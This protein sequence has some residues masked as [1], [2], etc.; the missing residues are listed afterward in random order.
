M[1]KILKDNLPNK[2]E[3]KGT[4]FKDITN[5]IVGRLTVLYPCERKNNKIYWLC[6]CNC[7]NYT[8]VI[9]NSL[10]NKKTKS[11]GCYTKERMSNYQSENLNSLIGKTFG[12][13]TVIEEDKII[14]TNS[15]RKIRTYKC[16][17]DCGNI[18][19]SISNSL[20]GGYKKSCGCTTSYGNSLIEKL[21]NDNNILFKKEYSFE[22][23]RGE[24]QRNPLRFDF[25]ILDKNNNLSYLIEY[26]GKQHFKINTKY[27]WNT[28]EHL[29]R[30]KKY[31]KFKNE[32][33]IKNKIPLIRIPYTHLFFLKIDDLQLEKSDFIIK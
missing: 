20:I 9:A 22:D 1:T 19:Y 25:A 7:G 30:V 10:I 31:D 4:R 26:D 28:E 18:T 14:T 17:C 33:C 21:L 15:G 32:Y 11:C 24:T 12:K 5:K 3:I 13:L 29:N 8:K 16:L 2:I 27:S 23:L 6:K